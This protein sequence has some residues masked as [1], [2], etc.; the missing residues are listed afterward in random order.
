MSQTLQTTGR[1]RRVEPAPTDVAVAHYAHRLAVET[2]C[3]DVHHDL[4]LGDQDIVVIDARSTEAFASGHVPG[5]VNIPHADIDAT[6]AAAAIPAGAIAVTY[7]AGPQCNASTL[8][9]LRLARLG[10]P[11]KE[12]LGGWD[13]WC[14]DGYPVAKDEL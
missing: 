4:G 14:R 1:I 12:M 13:Y 11:V 2:D 3:S 6:T 5:A 8:A 10:Y 9:A 7:C